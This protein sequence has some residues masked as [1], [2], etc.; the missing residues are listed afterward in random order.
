MVVFFVAPFKKEERGNVMKQRLRFGIEI[1]L[2]VAAI[3]VAI[4]NFLMERQV[5]Y[6]ASVVAV[7]GAV[8]FLVRDMYKSKKK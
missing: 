1:L 8:A 2:V 6:F 4:Y 7:C 5:T 3:T